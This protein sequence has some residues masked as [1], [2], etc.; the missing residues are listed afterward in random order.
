MCVWAVLFARID[1]NPEEKN[2]I[3]VLIS[4][5]ICQASNGRN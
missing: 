2:V 4:I 1:R 5:L 3:Q